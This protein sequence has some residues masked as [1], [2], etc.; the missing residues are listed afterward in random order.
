MDEPVF[1]LKGDGA[2]RMWMTDPAMMCRKHLLGE[3]VEL[4]MASAWIARGR[5]I[6]GWVNNNCL[7]PR[8]IARRHKALAREM[9]RRGYKHAS[10]LAQPAVAKHQ[11]PTARVDRDAAAKELRRRCL[12]CTRLSLD[13]WTGCTQ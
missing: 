7:E 1:E 12:D 9:M 11:C 6:D 5:R 2:M 4:H 8:A 3:H 13:C 10:P